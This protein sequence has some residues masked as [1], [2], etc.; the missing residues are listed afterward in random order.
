[1]EGA[2]CEAA[3][4]HSPSLSGLAPAQGVG[5]VHLPKEHTLVQL[6]SLCSQLNMSPD[7]SA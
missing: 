7:L 1:M 3:E 5:H 4:T 6:Y 2:L